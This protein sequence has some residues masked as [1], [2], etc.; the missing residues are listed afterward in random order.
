MNYTAAPQPLVSGT[1]MEQAPT[2]TSTSMAASQSA[3][4]E[5]LSVPFLTHTEPATPASAPQTNTG[6]P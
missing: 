4:P 2:A 5:L 6:L 3:M 1:V